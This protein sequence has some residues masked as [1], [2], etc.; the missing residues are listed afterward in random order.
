MP[1]L[2]VREC[3]RFAWF[4]FWLI[5]SCGCALSQQ[6]NPRPKIA[7]ALQGGGA[8][9][10]AHIGVLQWLEDHHIPV[11]YVA[12]TSM[13]G[14]VG[15]L[16]A[17]GHSST[18]LQEIIRSINWDEVLVGKTPYPDLAFRRKQ[19]ALE[20]PNHMEFGIKK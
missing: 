15:G 1:A 3:P 5:A 18:E 14:L 19:D 16:Y 12:G 20:Y 8:K 4:F 7:V 10:L 6:P 13:G 11:D 9:G 2:A 17:T